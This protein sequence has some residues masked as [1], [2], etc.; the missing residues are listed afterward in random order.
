MNT[1]DY[2]KKAKRQRDNEVYYKSVERDFS[3]EHE[4]LINQCVD[5]LLDDRELEQVA[6]KLLRPVQSRTPIY[7]ICPKYSKFTIQEDQ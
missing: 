4:Q 5:T 2:V 7:S 1:K 3:H 6:A